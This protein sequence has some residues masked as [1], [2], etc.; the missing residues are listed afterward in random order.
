MVVATQQ[1]T[2]ELIAEVDWDKEWLKCHLDPLYFIV[3][4]G[5]IL[6]TVKGKIPFTPYPHLIKIINMVEE[7]QSTI[8]LKGRQEGFTSTM[9]HYALWFALFHTGSHIVILSRSEEAANKTLA[10]SKF[11]WRNLPRVLKTPPGRDQ[12][13]LLEFPAIDTQ[14]RTCA[15]TETAGIGFGDARLVIMYEFAFHRA[16]RRNYDAI[17]PMIGAGGGRK[18][19]IGSAPNVQADD[20]ESKFKELY[21]QAV[22]GD[23]SF[24]HL[25]IGFGCMPYHT[26]E[27]YDNEAKNYDKLAMFTRYPRTEQ[28]ALTSAKDLCRFDVASL[29]ELI[30]DARTW[31]PLEI[32]QNGIIKIYKKP[33][34]GRRYCFSID[35][36]RGGG[37][38]SVG[39]IFDWQTSEEVAEFCGKISVDEQAR[40][41]WDLYREYNDAYCAP[42]RNAD[43]ERLIEKLQSFGVK[44]FY[45][46]PNDKKHEKPGWWTSG[47]NRPIMIGELADSI[48]RKDIRLHNPAALEQFFYFVRTDR[49]PEGEATKGANDDYV[50]ATAM[51]LQIRKSMP[52]GEGV[53]VYHTQYRG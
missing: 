48:A 6:D 45:Y 40:I 51:A 25:F 9:A 30:N 12:S 28:E 26:Q 42:E 15:A 20:Q 3:T 43:G 22:A 27:W 4:Y 16:G 17:R 5:S 21:I 50:I 41:A 36:A 24:A 47:H 31:Q 38:P 32:R 37:D 7:N 46:E 8:I 18:L 14:I 23:N 10:S 53:T 34:A 29:Q 39:L 2:L 19:V 13:S 44:N 1:Q 11:A 49:K 52:S 33:V 35:P